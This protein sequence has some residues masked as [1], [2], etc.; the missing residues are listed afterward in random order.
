MEKQI[1]GIKKARLVFS[2][3]Y[4]YT[5]SALRSIGIKPYFLQI[6]MVY[7][8]NT[9]PR[10]P[11]RV[12]NI[13][14]R[15]SGFDFK[16]ISHARHMWVNPADSDPQVWD[17]LYSKHND[18]LIR[19]YASFL[20]GYSGN[21]LLLLCEYGTDVAASK[22]LCET[23]GITDNVLWTPKLPRVELLSLISACDVG[24]GQFYSVPL[25]LWGGTA[26]EIM[27][28]G[29][30]V[31]QG[32][33]F[34]GAAY[35][36]IYRQPRPPLCQANSE[37]EIEGWLKSLAESWEFRTDIGERSRQWFDEYGGVQL[38]KRWLDLLGGN[39]Q[40]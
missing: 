26:L 34:D 37:S 39:E 12:Q 5:F 22:E 32:F 20:H 27:A 11:A 13:L 1:S 14:D 3:D 7:L 31:I 23:L 8:E 6:P 10:L 30:P 36:T 29:K 25:M 15:L 35:E 21:A 17:D 4:G 24:I 18:W 33:K 2:S 40:S 16:L 38:A 19:A 28:S 9:P